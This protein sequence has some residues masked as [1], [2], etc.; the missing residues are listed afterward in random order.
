[1]QSE[2]TAKGGS[3]LGIAQ[4]D[5]F[6]LTL[7]MKQ[8]FAIAGGVVGSEVEGA[9]HVYV[10]VTDE[11]GDYGWGEARPSPRWSY[12]T[13]ESV[14]TTIRHYLRPAL[15]GLC[16]TDVQELHRRMNREIASA[17]GQPLAKAAVDIALH[18]LIG[19]KRGESIVELWMGAEKDACSV[20]LSYL[21]STRDPE[22]AANKAEQAIRAGYSGMD[23]K[24]GVDPQRDIEILEAV[25]AVAPTQFLRVDAN[26]GYTLAQS[27]KMLRNLERLAVDVF[28]QP[29]PAKCL[30][31]TAALRRKSQV[32]IALD[33]S[34][35]TAKDL[36]QAIQLEACDT[37]VIKL[38]KMGGLGTARLCGEIA[39]EA[40]LGLLGGGLTESRLGL[41]A[42]TQ[43]FQYLQMTDPV[44]LNGPFFL[45]DDPVS[46]GPQIINGQVQ[47]AELPGIGCLIEE[48]K[49][50]QYSRR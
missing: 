45:A 50:L 8:S 16:I 26:Q 41:A 18:D 47:M 29:L 38:T 46:V 15:L 48:E 6:A 44:D 1:M 33:E 5:V 30:A 9:P 40:E 43:V 22:E 19:R 11:D 32:P 42:S 23:V 14:V 31:E 28:E 17:G 7:P 27:L 4:L 24:I 37:V 13:Q 36:L 10:K 39:R 3:E 25:R 34:I 20:S 21:I 2:R 12:E 49:V 35:W